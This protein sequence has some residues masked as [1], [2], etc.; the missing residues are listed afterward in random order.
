MS[1][2]LTDYSCLLTDNWEK[3]IDQWL[4]ED[5]PSFDFGGFIVGNEIKIAA[6][7]A[8]QE[9]TLS[10]SPFFYKNI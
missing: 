9:C 8:K 1:K 5:V 7:W 6:L 3:K 4:D 2:D 10:G